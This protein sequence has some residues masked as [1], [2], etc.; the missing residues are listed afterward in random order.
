V[1]GSLSRGWKAI[2]II[3]GLF[4]GL[5]IAITATLYFVEFNEY[6]GLLARQLS[7]HLGRPLK[8]DGDLKLHLGLHTGFSVAGL[9][10]AGA[11]DGGGDDAGDGGAENIAKIGRIS[12]GVSLLPLLR[13]EIVIDQMQVEDAEI[14]VARLPDGRLNWAEVFRSAQVGMQDAGVGQWAPPRI[15][16]FRLLN[17]DVTYRDSGVEFVLAV[18]ELK[19]DVAATAAP[20]EITMEAV[21]Q[22]NGTHPVAFT[23]QMDN[24][25]AFLAGREIQLD[26][27]FEF[28]GAT[29]RAKGR[30][31]HPLE[32]RGMDVHVNAQTEQLRSLLQVA[33]LQPRLQ[34]PAELAFDLTDRDGP[35]SVR[36]LDAKVRPAPGVQVRLT[37]VMADALALDG[38]D[39]AMKVQA[40]NTTQL[41]ALAG[42]ELPSIGP[43]LLAGRIGGSMARP[44]LADVNVEAGA[45]GRLLL[46]A[47][48]AITQPLAGTGLDLDIRLQGPD[49]EILS[50]YAG[51]A[52]PALGR[53]DLRGHLSDSIDAPQLSGIAGRFHHSDGTNI[54]FHGA[55]QNPMTGADMNLAF[56]ATGPSLLALAARSGQDIGNIHD[57]GLFQARAV[58]TGAIDDPVLRDMHVTFETT[59]GATL[60]LSGDVA[61]LFTGVGIDMQFAMAGTADA[62]L[63]ELMGLDKLALTEQLSVKGGVTGSRDVFR[64]DIL[65]LRLGSSDLAGTLDIDLR[66]TRPRVDADLHAKEF[67]LDALTA[68]PMAS[69]DGGEAK[70]DGRFIPDL[71]TNQSAL[72]LLDGSLKVRTTRLR[73]SDLVMESFHLEATLENGT[74]TMKPSTARLAGGQLTLNG[75][76]KDNELVLQASLRR[77]AVAD[78]GA[79]VDF[80][81]VDGSLD[82]SA[83][84]RAPMAPNL[85]AIAAGLNGKV[86]L[87]VT[88]GHVRSQ[89][90]EL[91]AKDLVVALVAKKSSEQGVRLHC[92]ANGYVIKDGLADS[93]V[94][95]LDTESMTVTGD[96]E[97]NLADEAI[98]Y[99]LA[100]KPKDPSLISL[101]TPINV[102]GTLTDP[103][104]APDSVAVAG[105]VAIAVVGNLLLPGVGLL[106]PLLSAGTGEAHPCMNVIK[107]GKAVAAPGQGGKS[108]ASPGV[109]EQM[110]GAVKSGAKSLM[111]LPGKVLE[112]K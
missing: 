46:T 3:S 1:A 30:I 78:L 86:S 63:A 101:A 98:R 44:T 12:F 82:F 4:L 91:L 15:S 35:L 58:L 108:G 22:G 73:K 68:P 66:G 77:A 48:G 7:Q 33:G 40:G 36:N 94:L 65:D 6:R 109:L 9:S 102:T 50:K 76:V 29:A 104:F 34:G 84:L 100:P 25:E 16:D 64:L 111:Q 51:T 21:L 43:V 103:G 60:T 23:G 71:A 32:G 81:D 110:G 89:L 99:R 97:T 28:A 54:E 31:F 79:M 75:H 62:V 5:I 45:A 96:G 105:S 90:L 14:L 42:V 47:T 37:G 69:V 85:R 59:S 88:D 20:A 49:S 106:L 2:R 39:F 70:S 112:A 74:L 80:H 53:F 55:V 13:R 57:P 27:T 11:G 83:D 95:L 10:L 72:T 56:K 18:Q 67:D 26:G 107:N 17:S 92:F 41:S 38:L 93:Q 87:V 8:I 24:L 61:R 19:A 52:I